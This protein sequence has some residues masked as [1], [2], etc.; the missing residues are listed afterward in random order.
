MSALIVLSS[1]M[2]GTFTA[3]ASN[4]SVEQLETLCETYEQKMDGSAY[5]NM[6][7]A[8][9]A[10]YNAKAYLVGV[11]A[12][13]ADAQDVDTY[14]TALESAIG[15]MG[16]W[17]AK[18]ADATPSFV[19]DSTGTSYDGFKNG[20]VD[21]AVNILYWPGCT[22]YSANG[23]T[24][25]V[26]IDLYYPTTVLMYDGINTPTMPVMARASKNTS[27]TRYLYQLYPSASASDNSNNAYFRL[28]E[29]WHGSNG[30]GDRTA[31]WTW[32]MENGTNGYPMAWAG[33]ASTNNRLEMSRNWWTNYVAALANGMQFVSTMDSNTYSSAYNLDWYRLSGDGADDSGFISNTNATI[34][35]VNYKAVLDAISSAD[36]ANI[37]SYSYDGAVAIINAVEECMNIDPNSYSYSS[38][39]AAAVS[40]CASAI[41]SA[42]NAVN[43]AKA[44]AGTMDT[45]SYMTL[46]GHYAEYADTYAAGQGNYT[47]DSW[48]A[49]SSEYNNAMSVLSDVVNKTTYMTAASSD[50][51]VNAFN[52]LDENVSTDVTYTYTF[53]NGESEQVAAAAGV[54]P[55][56]PENTAN[57][58]ATSN[59]NGTHTYTTYSWPEWVDGT[60]EYTEVATPVTDSCNM[61]EIE[62]AVDPIHSDGQLVDGKTAVM[63]CT[64][65]GY[66][67]GGEVI[68]A[69]EHDYQLSE[70]LSTAATCVAKGKNVYVCSVCGDTMTE[71]TEIDPNNHASVVTD[72]EVPATCT[73]TGLTEGSHCEACSAVIVAQEEIPALGHDFSVQAG[74]SDATCITPGTTTWKCSRC[75]ETEVRAGEVNPNNHEGDVALDPETVK[76]A[77]RGEDGYTGDT[78]CSACHQVVT[79]GEVIPALGVQITV[80]QNEL[81]A[82]TLNGEAT[83]GEAQKVAYKDSYTLTAT[84]NEGAEFV[85]WQVNGK[86]VSTNATYTTAAYADLTY[87]P[88]FAEKTDDF[89]VTFVDQF[90]MVL[91]TYT[92]SQIAELEAMPNTHTYLG[93]TFANWSM[94]LEEVKALET[95]AIVTAS[96]TKDDALTYTVSAPGCV[97]T[98]GSETY[99][100]TAEV[101]FD[102][103]VTVAPAEGTATAW[104]VNGNNA[105]Y[106]AEYTFY[107]TSDVE[108]AY[109][110]EEVTAAPTVAGVDVTAVGDGSV[111][112]LATRNVPEGYTLL[113]SG[114]VYGKDFEDAE[115]SLVLENANSTCYIYK[116]SNT[117]GDG[118]FALTFKIAAQT[119]V[120][121]ARAYIIVNDSE[122]NSSTYYAGVQSYDYDA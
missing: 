91:G 13:L 51:L 114:Y 1:L 89:T 26:T 44:S 54:A 102:K 39:A 121:Y 6:L 29:D 74:E 9:E 31:N 96:Y 57:T 61:E 112:F 35:V 59:N 43:N 120:A 38:D 77:T 111:R 37:T 71:E 76:E 55:V 34:Y 60:T 88:V 99:N 22:N 69:G 23:T 42:V 52:A 3:S 53:A 116:N 8:Y 87:V 21:Y 85:G 95:N 33:T 92:S 36:L 109:S 67:T 50:A 28:T 66:K 48:N 64:D 94:T 122:G 73:T 41:E 18:T 11:K 4:Y 119:G 105:A 86:L 79:K 103:A 118:Q 98:V 46:A 24:A 108:V 100:D 7:A 49:F 16:D 2:A 12:G 97:I 63:Q 106:G 56:A 117:A 15:S 17:S 113:E 90:N 70:E 32:T 101:G 65:C 84:A 68:P 5:T 62:A 80:E 45:D 30:N 104:T 110:S 83:T 19:D 81:G 107:V 58:A 25:N 14:Y 72:P 20:D 78:V 115:A 27:N 47:D 40:S 93:Y 10:W 75:E 82:T